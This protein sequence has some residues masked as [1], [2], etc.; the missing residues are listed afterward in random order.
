M[1]KLHYYFRLV[2][3]QAKASRMILS[4]KHMLAYSLA[5]VTKDGK[6]VVE[7]STILV[8][9]AMYKGKVVRVFNG[10][11]TI[12]LPKD[13]HNIALENLCEQIIDLVI[14]VDPKRSRNEQVKT[15]AGM[16][17]APAPAR[18]T[19]PVPVLE[20]GFM[21]VTIC[22]ASTHAPYLPAGEIVGTMGGCTIALVTIPIVDIIADDDGSMC[23][24]SGLRFR[25]HRD[26]AEQAMVLLNK[27]RNKQA[28]EQSVSPA[29]PIPPPSCISP[30]PMFD[31][32]GS[33]SSGNWADD[34]DGNVSSLPR[35]EEAN[36]LM[37]AFDNIFTRQEQKAEQRLEETQHQKDQVEQKRQEA[38]NPVTQNAEIMAQ[39]LH[40]IFVKNIDRKPLDAIVALAKKQGIDLSILQSGQVF[41]LDVSLL[42]A[43]RV[44]TMNVAPWGNEIRCGILTTDGTFRHGCIANVD[45]ESYMA[46]VTMFPKMGKIVQ[47]VMQ[48]RDELKV[49]NLPPSHQ[50]LLPMPKLVWYIVPI[51]GA[52]GSIMAYQQ[53]PRYA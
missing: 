49:R 26:I 22:V 34:A 52:D 4:L 43:K 17:T 44:L 38:I 53:V 13:L 41:F 16:R 35:E 37:G 14:E 25:F 29:S 50:G 36:A 42:L 6:L 33:T 2:S 31:D 32:D 46:L 47:E 51:I 10:A 27:A 30:M 7:C 12:I 28:E 18:A 11:I 48:V 19:V 45:Q 20:D 8:T 9:K 5:T 40:P 23:L 39:P 3:N 15:M 21:K 1:L 24:G